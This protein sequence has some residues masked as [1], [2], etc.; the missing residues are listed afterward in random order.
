M[1]HKWTA[2][3]RVKSGDWRREESDS[4]RNAGLEEPLTRSHHFTSSQRPQS[5]I[6]TRRREMIC[7]EVIISLALPVTPVSSVAV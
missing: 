1:W 7:D 5:L 6:P 3:W 4:W 2:A